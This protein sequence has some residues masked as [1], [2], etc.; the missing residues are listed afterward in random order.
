[1]HEV[2]LIHA[3]FDQADRAI[4]PHPRAAVRL[5]VVRIG[6][7]AGVDAGLFRTAFEGCKTERGYAAADLEVLSER[8]CWQ[9]QSCGGPVAPGGLLHCAACDASA[10]LSAGGELILQRVELEVSDV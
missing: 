7:L 2:S 4:E 5:L 1:M 3:L 9:C 6:E 10:R 8:A